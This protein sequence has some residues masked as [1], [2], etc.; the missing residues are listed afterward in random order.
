MV[1]LLQ[2]V[3]TAFRDWHDLGFAR[4]ANKAHDFRVTLFNFMHR[5]KNLNNPFYGGTTKAS[6]PEKNWEYYDDML[7]ER[8]R[9]LR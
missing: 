8:K 6:T 1:V 2:V 4:Y 7:D 9:R 3:W 5:D